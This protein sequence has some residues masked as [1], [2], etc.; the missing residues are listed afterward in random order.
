MQVG[1]RELVQPEAFILDPSLVLYLPLYELDGASF[2]SK[3]AYGHLCTVTGA[4]WTPRGRSFDGVDDY[5]TVPNHS[6]LTF[7]SE[8]FTIIE[9]IKPALGTAEYQALFFKGDYNVGGYYFNTHGSNG[10]IFLYTC[11]SGANQVSYYNTGDD[12]LIADTWAMVGVTRSGATATWYKNGEA[13]SWTSAAS[14]IDPA[15]SSED[16]RIGV[17]NDIA[18]DY[19][20]L[21]GEVWVYNRALTALEVQ[22]N[23][24]STRW[25]Y[26]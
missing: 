12:L 10:G 19:D 8:D 20:G 24:I 9:W 6:A 11:Q 21:I 4:S 17:N 2:M 18:L 16:A 25:R 5:I 7:T 13:K 14:H 26:Q 3:D 22:H 1:I 23:Y 15:T